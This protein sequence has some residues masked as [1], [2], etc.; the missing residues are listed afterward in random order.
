MTPNELYAREPEKTGKDLSILVGFYYNHL[1]EIDCLPY[2]DI[3]LDSEKNTRITIKY[4]K[5]FDFDGRRFW[6]LASVW[7][8]DKPIMII[9]NAGREGDD[10]HRRIIT[11]ASGYA[12][13]VKYVA[14]NLIIAKAF[15]QVEANT[16]DPDADVED[17]DSF[18][19]N[20]LDGYFARY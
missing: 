1:K 18:Y 3:E 17:L 19:G 12:D 14:H 2:Y 11:D 5:D 20:R 10:H 4:Y 8:D 13:M 16:Y 9:Q 7:F 15:D 6:L